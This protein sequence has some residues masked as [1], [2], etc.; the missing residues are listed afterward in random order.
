MKVDPTTEGFTGRFLGGDIQ[1]GRIAAA[2]RDGSRMGG[3]GYRNALWFPPEEGG[4]GLNTIEQGDTLFATLFVYGADQQPHWYS[5]SALTGDGTY[6][7]ALFESMGTPWGMPFDQG[8]VTRRQAGTM[9]VDLRGDSAT[10]TYDV[11]GMRVSKEIV[12]FAFKFISLGGSYYGYVTQPSSGPGGAVNDEVHIA[13]T[14]TATS[15]TMWT[16]GSVSGSCGYDGTPAQ[17]GS[18]VNVTGNYSCGDG[19]SGTFTLTGADLTTDGFT[20]R[21]TGG[22]IADATNGHIEGVR[23][24]PGNW[25]WNGWMSDLWIAPGESG[26]GLNLVGQGADN[27]FGTL[28]VYDENRRAKWYSMSDLHYIGR[29]A[30]ADSRGTYVGTITE[31]TGPWFAMA[32]FN[33]AA[34]ARRVVGSVS[35]KFLNNR[36]ADV[37]IQFGPTE[38]A[39]SMVPFAMR[40]NDLSG[41]YQGHIVT[42]TSSTTTAAAPMR[43][44]VTDNGSTV[45]ISS[46]MTGNTCTYTGSRSQY[47][48]R[49]GI[50]GTWTCNGNGSSGSFTISDAEVSAS[51][52]TAA[53]TGMP[54]GLANPVGHVG[55]A[56]TGPF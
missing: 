27:M 3:N 19:R 50:A 30:D 7:G 24:G 38:W 47:G 15:F 46:V 6:S 40:M 23:L 16:N 35:V 39:K 13:I 36:Q 9:Q 29:S 11:D 45:V 33:A 52:F 21:F 37:R 5:A 41:S 31:S 42:I 49:V 56:R 12:P 48:Q 55:G 25:G 17:R 4:W 34:V 18:L 22:R 10:L 53:M 20:A 54:G 28:F 14:H 2:R 8:T 1:L 44:N 32:S 43:L 51:G 26:W